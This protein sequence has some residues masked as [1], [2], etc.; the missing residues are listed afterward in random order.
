[1]GSV[2]SIV[3]P[4]ISCFRKFTLFFFPYNESESKSGAPEIKMTDDKKAPLQLLVLMTTF[5]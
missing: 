1:M 2:K 3:C 5:F 4:K